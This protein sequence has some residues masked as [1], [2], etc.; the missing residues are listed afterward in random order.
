MSAP[1]GPMGAR[2]RLDVAGMVLSGSCALHCSVVALA[3]AILAATGLGALLDESAE[4]AFTVTAVAVGAAAAAMAWRAGRSRKVVAGF[5]LSIG[6]LLA[7][8]VLEHMAAHGPT[9]S[10]A[11][12]GG[13]GLA[14]TH[15]VNLRAA[16][17]RA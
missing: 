1:G 4:W 14:L 17:A 13:V 12:L 16:T 7:G 9:E 15:V 3:P 10:L 11:V 8:R 5:L 2:A 6:A